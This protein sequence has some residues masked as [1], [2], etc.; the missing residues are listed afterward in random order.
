MLQEKEMLWVPVL[1]YH[2]TADQDR[3]SRDNKSRVEVVRE[4]D[5]VT[6]QE[7]HKNVYVYSGAENTLKISRVYST[8]WL[9]DYNMLY[10]PFDTQV[11]IINKYRQQSKSCNRS[12]MSFG[13]ELQR[14]D[15]V[16]QVRVETCRGVSGVQWTHR[17]HTV[18]RQ[19]NKCI[20]KCLSLLGYFSGTL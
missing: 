18:L 14:G 15:A 7:G 1:S 12:E 20:C 16:L 13:A 4:A 5:Y 8:Q 17:A 6:S 19:V 3:S 9:C 11:D 10:Y 2:N